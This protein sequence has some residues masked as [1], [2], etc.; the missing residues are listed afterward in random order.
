[1]GQLPQGLECQVG[2]RSWGR[3]W[4]WPQ[5]AT[6]VGEEG[7]GKRTTVLLGF[8]PEHSPVSYENCQDYQSG[9]GT[10]VIFLLCFFIPGC[11]PL[12]VVYVH[13]FQPPEEA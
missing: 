7:L 13:S 6:K 1:M 11:G 10:K 5:L 9:P 4:S 2:V 12:G 8:G 3:L